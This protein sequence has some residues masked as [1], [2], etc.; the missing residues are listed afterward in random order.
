MLQ[1]SPWRF[2]KLFA[3]LEAPAPPETLP[4]SVTC[5]IASLAVKQQNAA[6]ARSQ[7]C[8]EKAYLTY[9][10][11]YRIQLHASL[12]EQARLEV[13]VAR[14]DDATSKLQSE[15]RA[16]SSM[17]KPPKRARRATEVSSEAEMA[18]ALHVESEET[19]IQ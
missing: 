5:R 12:A 19:A 6:R 17:S 1:K 3:R 14:L 13:V 16:K 10:T 9:K 7:V 15:L 2:E 4:A 8:L 11:K 18:T